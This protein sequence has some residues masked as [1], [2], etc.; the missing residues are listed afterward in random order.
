MELHPNLVFNGNA[1]EALNHYRDALGGE[2]QI[3]RF[4]ESPASDQASPDWQ[5]K[6]IFGSLRSP[7]GTLNIMD[8]PPDRAGERGGNFM[9]SVNTETPQQTEAA[10]AKLLEGGTVVMPLEKTF[11]SP[12]F[13][14]LTDKFG[15]KWMINLSE[16]TR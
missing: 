8:A 5:D 14:M 1:E 12:R 13:G 16:A 11:W 7:G 3:M 6:V 4:A 10:F 2:L 15:I 9:L